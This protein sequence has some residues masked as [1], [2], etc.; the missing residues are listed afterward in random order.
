MDKGT[1]EKIRSRVK[2]N[3]AYFMSNYALL[4]AMTAIVVAMMH[5]GMV[6]FVAVVY[7]MWKAHEFLIRNSLNLFGIEVHALLTIKQRF[8][9]LSWHGNAGKRL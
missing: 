7:F 2:L 8:Y 1:P 5:P 9:V 4:A 6:F 3:V